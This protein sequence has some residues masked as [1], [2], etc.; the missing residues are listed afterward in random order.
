M[1]E[2]RD[3]KCRKKPFLG[4]L[5]V[6]IGSVLVLKEFGV[7][8]GH[9]ISFLL[10]W[11]MLLVAIG[12]ASFVGGNRTGGIILM[13]IGAFFIVPDIVDMP[14]HLE[15]LR[16]PVALIL[17]GGVVLIGHGR[18]TKRRHNFKNY[19]GYDQFE[20]FVIFGGREQMITSD[21][22]NGGKAAAIFGGLEYDLTRCRPA[23]EGALID[24]FT[25]F[26]GASFN[27]PPDWVVRN[28]ITTI[29]G[30]FSDERSKHPSIQHDPGKT[31]ILKG[32][33]LFG[34]G[35]IESKNYPVGK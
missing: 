11:K 5:L 17:I 7:I 1:K 4:I 14:E 18:F 28:E 32:M 33:C 30:G 23:P 21:N 25:M 10:T 9:V 34:G 6:L 8:P 2:C 35:S 16:W 12:V 24:V 29:F 27:I 19:G 22:F 26:G 3:Y 13:F 15:R 20:D 31:L